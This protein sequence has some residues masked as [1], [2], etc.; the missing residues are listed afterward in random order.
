MNHFYNKNLIKVH[1]R[2]LGIIIN[3]K[4]SFWS[5]YVT[6]L[7]IILPAVQDMTLLTVNYKMLFIFMEEYHAK[8]S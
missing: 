4:I 5:I 7:N 3:Q 2:S 8:Q 1:L 6:Q